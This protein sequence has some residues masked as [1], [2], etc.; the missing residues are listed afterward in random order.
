MRAPQQHDGMGH[1]LGSELT[2]LEWYRHWHHLL[3]APDLD[4]RHSR[5][6]FKPIRAAARVI[7]GLGQPGL[8]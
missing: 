2:H 6:I 7:D 5:S 4:T 1:G 3:D 8:L